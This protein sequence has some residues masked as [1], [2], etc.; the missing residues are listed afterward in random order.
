MTISR[1]PAGRPLDDG[2]E[3]RDQH[4]APFEREPLLADVVFLEKRLEELGGIE[5]VDNP[6]LLLGVELRAVAGRLHPSSS[7]FRIEVSRMCM[8]STPIVRQ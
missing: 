5:L 7:H 1:T 3:Q 4:L 2:V 6:P 8:N